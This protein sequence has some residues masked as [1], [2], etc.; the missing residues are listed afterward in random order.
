MAKAT[1]KL[2]Q[3]LRSQLPPEAAESLDEL[4]SMAGGDEDDPAEMELDEDEPADM[5]AD[6][7]SVAEESEE[8]PEDDEAAPPVPVTG[9][10]AKKKK[11]KLS[12]F[13]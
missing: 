5:P 11:S 7:N 12:F 8:L 13:A 2:I 10:V 9:N 4:E 1:F 3:Q 6:V